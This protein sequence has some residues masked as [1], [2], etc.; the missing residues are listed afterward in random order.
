[1]EAELSS[2]LSCS[3]SGAHVPSFP[4]CLLGPAPAT[5]F[6]DYSGWKMIIIATSLGEPGTK[7]GSESSLSSNASR[8]TQLDF[9][10]ANFEL[11]WTL[12][13]EGSDAVWIQMHLI[14][15]HCAM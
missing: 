1:M 7:Q 15:S 9:N 2:V 6:I 10:Y 14:T 8:D 12:V 13:D 4:G 11:S 3:E 5:P